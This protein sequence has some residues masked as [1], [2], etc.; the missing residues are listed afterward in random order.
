MSVVF[1]LFLG[2]GYGFGWFDDNHRGHVRKRIRL[3]ERGRGELVQN[4]SKAPK[5]V[6]DVVD[7]V[8]VGVMIII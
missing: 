1:L 6:S 8:I 7:V 2:C 4:P 5:V 3:H